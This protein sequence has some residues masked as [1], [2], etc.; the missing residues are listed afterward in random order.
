IHRGTLHLIL[1]DAVKKTLGPDAV[2][3]DHECT[4]VEQDE[5]GTTVH[6]K[7]RDRVRAD[8]VVDCEGIN[9]ALRKQFYP[10]DQVAFSGINTWRGV[11][12]RKPIL[13]G[14][15]YMRV[16]SIRTGKIV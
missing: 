5:T 8:V 10:D 3:T 1:Y 15:S 2:V 12:R 13:T 11:T 6:F 16:G 4:G 7:K 9:S 14:R